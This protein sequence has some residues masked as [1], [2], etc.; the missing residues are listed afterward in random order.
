MVRVQACILKE[1]WFSNLFVEN[2]MDKEHSSKMRVG[3]VMAKALQSKASHKQ[4]RYQ[5][6][7]RMEKFSFLQAKEIK[8]QRASLETSYWK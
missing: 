8:M 5:K 7:Q 2:A 4:L 6:E 3:L 1:I